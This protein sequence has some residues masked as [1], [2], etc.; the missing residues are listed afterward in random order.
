[1][2]GVFIISGKS[3]KKVKSLRLMPGYTKSQMKMKIMILNM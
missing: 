1:M 3:G 2:S